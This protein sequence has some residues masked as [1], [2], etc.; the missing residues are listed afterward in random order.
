MMT[1]NTTTADRIAE[2]V[3]PWRWYGADY[4]RAGREGSVRVRRTAEG[5]WRLTAAWPVREIHDED[6]GSVLCRCPLQG[7]SHVHAERDY[8]DLA[9]VVAAYEQTC[10]EVAHRQV[11]SFASAE[12]IG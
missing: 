7:R 6:P 11:V 12:R 4:G 10:D 2:I 5:A 8:A 1:T 9:E 3:V